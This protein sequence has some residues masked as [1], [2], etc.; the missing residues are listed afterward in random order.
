VSFHRPFVHDTLPG[1]HIEAGAPAVRNRFLLVMSLIAAV[2]PLVGLLSLAATKGKPGPTQ[3]SYTFP[4]RAIPDAPPEPVA[5]DSAPGPAPTREEFTLPPAHYWGREVTLG[6]F[7]IRAVNRYWAGATPE[8]V[9][10]N[11]AIDTGTCIVRESGLRGYLTAEV[12]G[13][14]PVLALVGDLLFGGMQDRLVARS[15]VLE[16]G[17][18]S[19]PVFTAETWQWPAG[20][21]PEKKVMLRD[22]DCPQVDLNIK[23]A[24]Y[25]AGNQHSVTSA[26]MQVA[27]ELEVPDGQGRG[28]YRSAYDAPRAAV[29]EEMVSRARRIVW[30][31]TV[32]F[33]VY[34]GEKLIAADLFEST[35]LLE[36]LAD[37]LLA[38]Y[39]MTAVYGDVS[40]WVP[41]QPPAPEPTVDLI[42]PEPPP[43]RTPFD[44]EPPKA[45]P[46]IN[47]ADLIRR[48]CRRTPDSNPIH[49]GFFRK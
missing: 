45:T 32:G 38:S 28:A 39:A 6:E 17:L 33:V 24:V 3:S 42:L 9:T 21:Q 13:H 7:T 20:E 25:Q 46:V 44:Y 16:P 15:V 30:A 23:A 37:D 48:E 4:A 10:L 31:F 2:V 1:V 14:S 26:I 5:E 8:V 22:N 19:V 11:R 29:I 12:E 40:N 34:H 47:D 49:T 43:Y 36:T 27:L 35:R 41:E 18:T